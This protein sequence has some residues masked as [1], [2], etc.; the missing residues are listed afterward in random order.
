MC[1]SDVWVGNGG[2]VLVVSFLLWGLILGW[3]LTMVV[4][5]GN[6]FFFN[7]SG[8]E[9]LFVAKFW[10]KLESGC[11]SLLEKETEGVSCRF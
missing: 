4:G 10:W 8:G 11:V 1:F 3:G 9:L 2:W 7:F 6:F 5:G